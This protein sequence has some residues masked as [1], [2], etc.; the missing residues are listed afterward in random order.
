M[1][2]ELL[3]LG[4]AYTYFKRIGPNHPIITY[5]DLEDIRS[6]LLYYLIIETQHE[7]H[8]QIYEK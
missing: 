3:A 8:E 2:K 7:Q 4:K 1:S 6:S 5:E